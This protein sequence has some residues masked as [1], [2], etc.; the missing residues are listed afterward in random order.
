MQEPTKEQ[1]QYV[2]ENEKYWAEDKLVMNRTNSA[3]VSLTG[4][5]VNW[6][7]Y[8]FAFHVWLFMGDRNSHHHPTS[9][10]IWTNSPE[11]RVKLI[12][13]FLVMLF[14]YPH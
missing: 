6:D 7:K 12:L 14:D 13:I 8:K 4:P 11:K 1:W 3:S 2:S 5:I 10:H 9:T